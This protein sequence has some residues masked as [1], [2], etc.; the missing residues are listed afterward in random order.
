MQKTEVKVWGIH[1]GALGEIDSKFL[2]KTTPCIAIGW[3]EVGDLGKI[4]A[5]REKFK[6]RLVKGYPETKKGAIPT[7]AGMLYRIVHEMQIGDIVI[8][9]SKIDKLIHIGRVT[10]AYEYNPNIDKNYPN[11]RPVEWLKHIPRTKFSQGA[12]YEIGSALSL[13]Q[14]KNYADE[15]IAALSGEV[16]S[17]QAEEDVTV[18]KVAEEIEQGTR[19]FIAK[20]LVQELKGHPFE[21]FVAHVLNILGY[22]TRVSPEGADGGIDIIAHKDE[23][24]LEPPIIKVQVKSNDSDIT[25]DKVQA[26]YGNV[27]A[28]EYGLFVAINGFSKKAREFAKSKPNLRIIDGDELIDILL[29]HYEQLDSKYKAIIP[30]KNV[31]IPVQ[32]DNEE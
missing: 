4:P 27:A 24:G 29:Q 19:D 13:F 8:Y 17:G 12:L 15:F 1:A 25:P 23:L 21:H 32:V 18:A 2:S 28:G 11:L 22:R 26:L 16:I 30:L 5:D 10:G 31:Y 3:S 6:E 7:S 9:P 20:R 14:V